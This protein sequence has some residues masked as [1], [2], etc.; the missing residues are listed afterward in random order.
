VSPDD[1]RAGRDVGRWGAPGA[2]GRPPAVGGSAGRG[3]GRWGAPGAQGRPPAVGGRRQERERGRRREVPAVGEEADRLGA[4][5]S[6]GE[7]PPGGCA[8]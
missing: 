1:G 5:G 4:G 6:R 8:G 7:E 2:Q 3:V